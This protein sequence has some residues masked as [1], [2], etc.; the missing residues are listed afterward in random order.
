MAYETRRFNAAFTKGSPIIPV[1]CRKGWGC[2]VI[3]TVSHL[4]HVMK[5]Q[6]EGLQFLPAPHSKLFT[7]QPRKTYLSAY[8]SYNSVLIYIYKM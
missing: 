4:E 2:A 8:K 3:H 1:L 6:C 7:T 5:S